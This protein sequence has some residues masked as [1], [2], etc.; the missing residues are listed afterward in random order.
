MTD[1]AAT[2]DERPQ[3]P[4][5]QRSFRTAFGEPVY[6][7]NPHHAYLVGNHFIILKLG[8]AVLDKKRSEVTLDELTR[9][10]AGGD[11]LT[12]LSHELQR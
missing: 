12:E 7:D 2:R 3:L 5:I 6:P 1:N 10:M 8:Q 11:E 9:Q 4:P